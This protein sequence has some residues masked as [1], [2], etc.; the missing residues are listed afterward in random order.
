MYISSYDFGFAKLNN[1]SPH[2][3]YPEVIYHTVGF[4]HGQKRSLGHKE[5]NRQPRRSL[6]NYGRFLFCRFSNFPNWCLKTTRIFCVSRINLTIFDVFFHFT[7]KLWDFIGGLSLERWQ[8]L[9]NYLGKFF[10]SFWCF[11]EFEATTIKNSLVIIAHVIC[12]E[13]FLKNISYSDNFRYR[14]QCDHK[15]VR[16]LA[17]PILSG[18]KHLLYR[19]DGLPLAWISL[20]FF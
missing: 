15:I 3:Y 13:I 10:N 16:V 2:L 17:D 7:L 20:K 14:Y 6:V 1:L 8:K 4:I 5:V 11:P 12:T 9:A 19:F 18:T